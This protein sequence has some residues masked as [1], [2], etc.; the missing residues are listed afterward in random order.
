MAYEN[1]TDVSPALFGI[2][3]EMAPL[4]IVTF[5]PLT[6]VSSINATG[7]LLCRSLT[8]KLELRPFRNLSRK[9]PQTSE[10]PR[11]RRLEAMTRRAR[12]LELTFEQ[13]IP[14]LLGQRRENF[15]RRI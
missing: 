4:L 3:I 15:P 11:A 12:I 1:V 9:N 2:T 14:R 8:P 5:W 6:W 13:H 7:K 10:T